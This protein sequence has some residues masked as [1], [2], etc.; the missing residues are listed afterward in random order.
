MADLE[1]QRVTL[2][3]MPR[4]LWRMVK[5][6]AALRGQTVPQFVCDALRAHLSA[7]P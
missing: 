3:F 4:D 2:H 5:S 7:T 1:T 6:A